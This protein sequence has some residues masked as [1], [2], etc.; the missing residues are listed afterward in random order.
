MYRVMDRQGNIIDES[1]DPKVTFIVFHIL[2]YM[3]SSF[4][5]RV[6]YY[7]AGLDNES[8]ILAPLTT[9]IVIDSLLFSFEHY[10]CYSTCLILIIIR[11]IK[12]LLF[13]SGTRHSLMKDQ[14]VSF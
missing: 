1:Q 12:H 14:C 13:C 10:L 11:W 6:E 2:E 3:F 8:H 7:R 5:F 9:A 4:A